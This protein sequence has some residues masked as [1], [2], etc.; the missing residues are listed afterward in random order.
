MGAGHSRVQTI[1]TL[2]ENLDILQGQEPWQAPLGVSLTFL[3]SFLEK[4]RTKDLSTEEVITQFVLAPTSKEAVS[5][6]EWAVVE[7]TLRTEDVGIATHFVSHSRNMK[8]DD[9]CSALNTLVENERLNEFAPDEFY[10]NLDVFCVNLHSPPWENGVQLE[11]F[12]TTTIRRSGRTALVLRSWENPFCFKNIW[13]LYELFITFITSTELIVCLP[14]NFRRKFDKMLSQQFHTLAQSLENIDC[15]KT[16][17]H[18]LKDPILQRVGSS[19]GL[20]YMNEVIV[21]TMRAWLLEAGQQ[22]LSALVM[23]NGA[24]S[25]PVAD[26]LKILGDWYVSLQ[27]YEEAIPAFSRCLEIYEHNSYAPLEKKMKILDI[28]AKML[29]YMGRHAEALPLYAKIVDVARHIYGKS[30]PELASSLN[31]LARAHCSC[32]QYDEAKILY[33]NSLLL[34]EQAYGP[35]DPEVAGL[36]NNLGDLYR[37]IGDL[38]AALP[39][40]Q[41]SLE[42]K[43][44]TL[45]RNHPSIATS[46]NN[47]AEVLKHQ[48]NYDES[49]TL[50]NRALSIWETS[51]KKDH[52][53]IGILHNNLGGLMLQQNRLE[54]AKVY[55]TRSLK[56]LQ[57]AL[58]EDSETIAIIFSN[59]GMVSYSQGNYPEAKSYFNHCYDAK[60]RRQGLE[61]K[62]VRTLRNWIDT[63]ANMNPTRLSTC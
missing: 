14:K 55:Y 13:S 12:L 43:E 45:D 23:D 1:P 63:E 53:Q 16:D 17:P 57:V 49:F 62:P 41:R 7:Q 20:V 4:N 27:K 26:M 15:R 34:L 47:Q 37:Q 59:L 24:E 40:L 30:S 38:E 33:E 25:M 29:K 31:G 35:H 9:L 48:G 10:F 5:Y 51:L 18:A 56:I 6:V 54:E 32:E 28:L 61:C 22:L 50:Y 42:I 36:L 8:F 3:A 39:L 52:P 58:G 21:V 60:V 19:V 11:D 2:V 44:R 46:L